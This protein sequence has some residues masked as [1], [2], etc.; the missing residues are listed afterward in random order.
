[1][2]LFELFWM[3]NCYF[4]SIIYGNAAFSKIDTKLKVNP[5]PGKILGCRK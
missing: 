5:D 4:P 3:W 1:M 2:H